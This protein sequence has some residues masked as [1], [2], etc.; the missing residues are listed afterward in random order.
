MKFPYGISDFRK[1]ITNNYFYCDRTDKIPLLEKSESQLFI[2]PRRFGKSLLLSMLENYY[3]VAKKEEFE[4]L[5]GNLAIGKTPTKF[6][7]SYFILRLDFSC[8]DTTGDADAIKQSLYNHINARI[9]SFISYYNFKGFAIPENIIKDED[10]LFSIESLLS[11]IRTTP[12]P[13]YLLIDEYDNFAN[14]IMMGVQNEESR[15]KALV[16]NEGVLRTLFKAIKSSTSGSMFDRVFITGVS[17]VVLSDITSG[18]NIAQNIYFEPEFNDLC[19]FREKEVRSAVEQITTA[20]DFDIEKIDEATEL[21]KIYYNG[22]LFSLDSKEQIYNPTLCLYFLDQFQKKCTYPR[23]MLD[24]N[25][26]VDE[27]KLEYIAQIP[28]GRDLLINL[29]QKDQNVVISDIQDRFGIKEMLSDSSKDN[30]FLV[31]FLYYFGVLTLAG[32]TDDLKINLKVPNMVMQSLYVE[33][34]QQML[35][36]EP[37]ERDNGKSAAELVYQKGNIEPLCDFVENNYF[38]V[39]KNRDYRWAN[40]L[41]LK[42]AFLTLLYNDIIFIMDSEAEIHRRYADLTMIIRPDKRHATVFDVLIE[43]KFVTLKDAGITG[44][45]AKKISV[46]ELYKIPQIASELKNGEK[47][48]LDYGKKLNNKYGN[49]RLKKFV[50]VSLGFERVCYKIIEE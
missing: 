4:D 23:K 39:F 19:G 47:Q 42:T 22:Y 21:I 24:S 26:A 34:I 16:H 50:V 17:P 10:A 49:L 1:I 9:D 48:V 11:S 20:C 33:R 43:F 15:Y 18:Y 32:E 7:N 25:L 2:R 28:K 37:F 12:Y 27:S 30:A 3:D 38:K 5:F 40:E 13:I 8:V 44:K 14:T 6:R 46:D 41:T 29:M 35:L 36:P 31:S 45:Q